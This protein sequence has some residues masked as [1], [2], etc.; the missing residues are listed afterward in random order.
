MYVHAHLQCAPPSLQ[1][2]RTFRDMVNYERSSVGQTCSGFRADAD[3]E[4]NVQCHRL[5]L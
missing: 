4:P 5:R 1:C 2:Y 3:A